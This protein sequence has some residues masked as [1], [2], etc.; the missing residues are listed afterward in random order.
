MR[1]GG[2][3][4]LGDSE[5]TINDIATNNDKLSSIIKNKGITGL[6]LNAGDTYQLELPANTLFVE[7]LIASHGS[8]Y[9]GGQ[10]LTPG[11]AFSYI[12]NNDNISSENVNRG[13]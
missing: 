6:S 13:L 12:T 11:T 1:I 9:S 5:I 7:P 4:K 10:F 8:Q 3:T 2:N